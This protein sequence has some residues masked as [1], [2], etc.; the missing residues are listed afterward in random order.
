MIVGNLAA[1]FTSF[2]GRREEVAEV[3]RLLGAARLV[4]LTGADGMGKTRLALEVAAASAKAFPGGV[5]LVDLASMHEPSA[6]ADVAAG[7]LAV[8]DVGTRPLVELLAAHLSGRRV[9]L[10]LD[11]WSIWWGL[12][13]SWRS[14]CCRPPLSCGSW[15]PPGRR[16]V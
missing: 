13:R 4:T 15:R 5:R 7:T 16:S 14:S 3:R 8:A 2:V 12:A 10:V 9:L 6:V 11:N 1:T